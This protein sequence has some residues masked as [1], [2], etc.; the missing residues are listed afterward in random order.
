MIAAEF[1]FR[2]PGSN[3]LLSLSEL[4]CEMDTVIATSMRDDFSAMDRI[5]VE[6]FDS[7]VL[8]NNL[9][10]KATLGKI[11]VSAAIQKFQ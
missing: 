7:R 3:R 4:E 2:L 9:P 5:M 10:T 6:I 11:P 8:R 1:L